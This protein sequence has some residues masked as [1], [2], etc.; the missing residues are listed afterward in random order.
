MRNRVLTVAVY[1]GT[2][3][4]V[5]LVVT[6]LWMWSSQERVVF[7]PPSNIPPDPAGARRVAIKASDGQAGFAYVVEPSSGT[8]SATVIA[9]H[10]NADLAAWMVPWAQEVARRANAIVVIPEYRGYGG[11]PGPITFEGVASDAQGALAYAR[12]VQPRRLVLYGHSLGTAIAVQLAS[13]ARDRAPDALVLQSPFTSARDMAARMLVPAVPWLWNR[14]ARLRYDTRSAVS[15]LDIP[16]SVA[17]GTLDLTIPTRMGREVHAAA[18]RKGEFLLVPRAGHNDVAESGG[19]EYWRWL[20][21]A[22]RG[23]SAPVR[24]LEQQRGGRLP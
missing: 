17:H 20:T 10:G 23:A 4:L 3:V 11:I 5:W 8:P 2:A 13:N 1:A 16:V 6:T 22:V 21:T 14:I 9:F 19:E 24:E 12:T 15:E 7:Q 18:R